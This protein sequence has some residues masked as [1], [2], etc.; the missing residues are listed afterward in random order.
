MDL[1]GEAYRTA[2]LGLPGALIWEL[3]RCE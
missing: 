2:L 3:I 1:A